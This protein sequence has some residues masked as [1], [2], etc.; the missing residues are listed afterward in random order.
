MTHRAPARCEGCA[1]LHCCRSAAPTPAVWPGLRVLALSPT[2]AEFHLRSQTL[3]ILQ[4]VAES[5]I[6]LAW[7][8]LAALVQQSAA[9]LQLVR[10]AKVGVPGTRLHPTASLGIGTAHSAVLTRAGLYGLR[11]RCLQYGAFPRG[12]QQYR[13]CVENL[14]TLVNASNRGFRSLS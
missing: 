4:T 6:G 2:S 1:V 5:H 11:R 3:S 14:R 8:E 13:N 9:A 10:F 7:F 12:R